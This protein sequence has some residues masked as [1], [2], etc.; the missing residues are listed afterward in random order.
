[1]NLKNYT[2]SVPASRSA[3]NIEKYLVEIGATDI[4]KN[5][6]NQELMAISFKMP[7]EVGEIPVKLPANVAA[8][9]ELM[10]ENR[11]SHLSMVQKRKMIDQAART[12]W[13]T[14]HEWVMIQTQMILLKQ[15]KFEEIFMPYIWIA[16]SGQTLFQKHE[17]QL[18]MLPKL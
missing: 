4:L 8:V 18:L 2:S 13:K 3:A 14:L 1:M 9:Y 7:T 12:A 11:T 17:K 5:Y 10:Q 16:K 6:Q 15:A